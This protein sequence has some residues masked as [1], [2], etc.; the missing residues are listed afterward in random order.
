MMPDIS[1]D[2]VGGQLIPDRS[3]K[4]PIFPKLTFPEPFLNRWVLSKQLAGA[5][6]F[7]GSHYF[8]DRIFR[9]ERQK[10]M[11]MVF[12][13]FHLLN[14]VIVFFSDLPEKLS[15]PLAQVLLRE[16]VFPIFWTPYQMVLGVIDRVTRSSKR[17][18]AIVT[19]NRLGGIGGLPAPL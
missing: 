6:T 16:Q 8:A 17:H 11:D 14:V 1:F 3:R 12:R 19:R 2:H 7:Q 15:C 10:D 13:Y 9:R 4:V 18:A 5:D